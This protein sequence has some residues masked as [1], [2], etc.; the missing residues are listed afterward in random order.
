MSKDILNKKLDK[1]YEY[2]FITDIEQETLPPGLNSDVIKV[3][4]AKKDEPKW[5]LEWRLNAYE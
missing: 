1:K 2:G 3:I 5:L 4:S